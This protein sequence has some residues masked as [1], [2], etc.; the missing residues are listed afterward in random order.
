MGSYCKECGNEG[1]ATGA[2]QWRELREG[3]L[4]AFVLQDIKYVELSPTRREV[5]SELEG[6]REQTAN[7]QHQ[8]DEREQF[9]VSI[10]HVHVV[11]V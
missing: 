2:W 4:C 11:Q 5:Y 3:G 6:Y 10:C 1:V 9:G 8:L 7:S